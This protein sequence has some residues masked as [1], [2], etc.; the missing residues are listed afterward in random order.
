[1]SAVHDCEAR[2]GC[3]IGTGPVAARTGDPVRSRQASDNAGSMAAAVSRNAAGNPAVDTSAPAPM[4][5][6][7][8]P[9]SY[10]AFQIALTALYPAAG[11]RA[12]MR[13][14]VAFCRTPK[15][16]PKT[17]APATTA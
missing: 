16:A 2:Q 8:M 3:A 17:A 10:A 7:A 5:P 15:P 11:T 14:S 4:A 1:M 12:Y 6:T 9:R 13:V